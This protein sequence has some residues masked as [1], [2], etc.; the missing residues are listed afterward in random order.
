VVAQLAGNRERAHTV[1]SDVGERHWR[2][3][4]VSSWHRH[5]SS[6]ARPRS[7]V[8]NRV[9]SMALAGQGTLCRRRH[10]FRVDRPGYNRRLRPPGM[11]ALTH[12]QSRRSEGVTHVSRINR[13]P[14][15]RYGHLF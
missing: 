2:T 10:Q 13:N 9:T 14:C 3:A 15:V 4:V 1:R 5:H 11:E 6:D 8:L 7:V 12:R